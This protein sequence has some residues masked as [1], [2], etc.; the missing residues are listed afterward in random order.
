[1]TF[2]TRLAVP[3][4]EL[5]FALARLDLWCAEAQ[6]LNDDDRH[7]RA[8][9]L[10]VAR[11][12]YLRAAISADTGTMAAGLADMAVEIALVAD[13]LTLAI[14]RI[15]ADRSSRRL[16]DDPEFDDPAQRL[17]RRQ[18]LAARLD[19]VR[20]IAESATAV[21][22]HL[23]GEPPS[24]R[25]DPDSRQAGDGKPLMLD[26]PHIQFQ[27]DRGAACNA[28]RLFERAARQG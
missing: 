25:A 10:S 13:E 7:G 18:S 28:E 15:D 20:L 6:A 26:L 11:W 2:Q 4:S 17:R 16:A 23:V 3:G 5:G 22:R 21:L 27:P 12:H 9:R 1:M 19:L 24:G 8:L 14:A